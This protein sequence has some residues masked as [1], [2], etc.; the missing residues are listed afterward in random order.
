MKLSPELLYRFVYDVFV[1]RYR[2]SRPV[3]P[4]LIAYFVTFRCNLNCLYCEYAQD[5]RLRQ[6]PEL[7]TEAA[8][9]LL[10]ILRR[11]APSLAFSGGEPLLREDI[12]DLVKHARKLGFKPISLFTNSLLLPQNEQV[13]DYIDFLQ[14]SL[15]TTDEQKQDRLFAVNGQGAAKE[16]M[17]HIRFY[18]RQQ[19]K[20]NFRINLNAVLMPETLDDLDDVYR[21]ARSNR[22]RLT[23]CPQLYYGQPVDGIAQNPL[24]RQKLDWL[25]LLKKKDATIMDTFQFLESIR[26]FKPFR[27]YPY[28]TPRV[29]PNGDLVA[30]C[31]ILDQKR[32][33]LLEQESWQAA[34]DAMIAEFGNPFQCPKPCFLP[35]YLETSTLLDKPLESLK[36]LKGLGRKIHDI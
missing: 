4:L 29:Y 16:V 22:V 30:P 32:W 14:V 3:R 18:A 31:P 33:P 7:D 5:N 21:F 27:C 20:R 24:Y 28:L 13:L 25:R 35:C 9:R 34:Y 23:V 10:N 17:E 11:G 1:T 15:D 2:P 36:E 8:M 12:L 26:D 6:Q 19:T